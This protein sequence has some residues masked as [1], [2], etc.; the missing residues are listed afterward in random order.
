MSRRKTLFSTDYYV[1]TR[2]VFLIYNRSLYFSHK[3]NDQLIR[4]VTVRLFNFTLSFESYSI[5]CCLVHMRISIFQ[6]V[7]K[8]D[9]IVLTVNV[10]IC[11]L[12]E[13][14]FPLST[15]RRIYALIRD[16]NTIFFF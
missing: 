11:E 13:R 8:S 5:D 4:Y 10:S 12:N 1:L 9:F 15:V 14:F 6:N 3:M 16:L 7:L 2:Y